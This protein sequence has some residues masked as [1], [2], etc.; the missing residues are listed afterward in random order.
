[1]LS[2]H[3]LLFSAVLFRT[4]SNIIIEAWYFY[5]YMYINKRMNHRYS[6]AAVTVT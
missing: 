4:E 5:K 1:M 3:A 6:I 2:L